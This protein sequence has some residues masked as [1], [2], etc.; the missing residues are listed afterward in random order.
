LE[1]RL[2]ALL[3]VL[4]PGKGKP[5][6]GRL[7]VYVRDDRNA[8]STLAPAVWFAYIQQTLVAGGGDN[9]KPIVVRWIK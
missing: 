5:K 3:D 6:T 9:Y 2:E 1:H 8:G 7:W 4:Q